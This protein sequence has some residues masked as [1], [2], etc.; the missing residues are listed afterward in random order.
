MFVEENMS[1]VYSREGYYQETQLRL[2]FEYMSVTRR[3]K[4]LSLM[5]QY[6]VNNRTKGLHVSRLFDLIV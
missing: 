1:Q 3:M 2:F 5:S 6:F 4:I